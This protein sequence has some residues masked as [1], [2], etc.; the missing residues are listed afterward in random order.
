LHDDTPL[1][2][3]SLLVAHSQKPLPALHVSPLPLPVHVDE[4]QP[5]KH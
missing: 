1:A 3:H 2:L 4:S 5:K